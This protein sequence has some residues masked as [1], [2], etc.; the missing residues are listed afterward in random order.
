M[1]KVFV[2]LAKHWRGDMRISIL[3]TDGFH[4]VVPRLTAWASKMRS[5]GHDVVLFADKKHLT[6]GDILFL[7]SCSQIIRAT[8]RSLYKVCLVLH[9]SDLPKGRGWSPHIWAIQGGEYIITVSLLEANDAVDTGPI[10][11]KTKFELEGHELLQEINNLL[12]NAELSLMD[13][14]VAEFNSVR[15]QIQKGD[16]GDYMER[17]T[18]LNSQIDP[19]LSLASQFDLLRIVDNDRYPAFFDYRGHRYILRVEK[20]D[21]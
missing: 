6:G 11:F 21:K 18:P 17:R 9:A 1:G 10:W 13:R 14:A 3:C 19:S 16:S 8:E 15:P 4:P 7:V 20:S 5:I 12:F 2:V